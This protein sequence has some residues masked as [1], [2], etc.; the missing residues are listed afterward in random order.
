V[1]A[2]ISRLPRG[3]DGIDKDWTDIDCRVAARTVLAAILPQF[4]ASRSQ[5]ASL[6]RIVR[7]MG[8]GECF[9]EVA[10]VRGAPRTASAI[11]YDHPSDDQRRVAS[12]V[13]LVRIPGQAF[14]EFLGR[15]PRVAERVERQLARY[16]REDIAR[17]AQPAWADPSLFSS[18]EFRDEGLIQGQKLLLIDL[19]RCTRCGDCVRACIRTHED[20]YT[21][22]FL[23]GPRFGRFLIPAACRQCRDP[24]CMIGCPVGSIQRGDN[25]E[26]VIRDW[27]IGCGLCARQCPYDSIQMHDVGLITESALG[28]QIMPES[29]VGSSDWW[30]VKANVRHWPRVDAPFRWSPELAALLAERS[31]LGTQW[32]TADRLL[33]PIC[34]RYEFVADSRW[35]QRLG[36]VL[37]CETKA[38]QVEVWLNG[39]PCTLERGVARVDA[40]SIRTGKNCLALRLSPTE[41]ASS[42]SYEAP[43][44]RVWLGALPEVGG[45]TRQFVEDLQSVNFKLQAARAVVCDLCSHLPGQQPACVT[46]CP[47][48]AAMRVDAFLEFPAT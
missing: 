36:F 1:G 2:Q 17:R 10:V 16:Q 13:E 43:L 39:Q 11:A 3:L 38:G 22:L 34:L 4:I 31:R 33:E 26:I 23:D 20:G 18:P 27:C 44:L 21:R 24:L 7:Y 45:L 40:A 30:Q 35:Q 32:Q 8:R 37:E 9:G 6:P 28:W 15:V 47:H 48:A 14:R 46:E 12:R 19:D 42:F 29:A 5:T 25:G 41:K